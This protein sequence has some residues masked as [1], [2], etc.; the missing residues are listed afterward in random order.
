MILPAMTVYG[1][2]YGKLT[3]EDISITFLNYSRRF[4]ISILLT[5]TTELLLLSESDRCAEPQIRT[6]PAQRNTNYFL[7]VLFSS[8]ELKIYDYNRIIIDRNGCTFD[9]FL[10]KIKDGFKI[11]KIGTKA[12]HPAHKGEFG[13]Y[14]RKKLV[15]GHH[16][17]RTD[18]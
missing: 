12:Y 10:D 7:S 4:R 1:I 15:S 8:D 3:T 17:S 11:R 13:L 5:D 2:R 18:V 16:F 14:F 9:S 6:I